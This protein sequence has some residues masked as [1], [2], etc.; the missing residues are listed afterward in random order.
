MTE[1][2][3]AWKTSKKRSNGYKLKED[4]FWFSKYCLEPIGVTI[5]EHITTSFR[6]N[7]CKAL[8]QVRKGKDYS[9]LRISVHN[10]Q[11]LE[12]FAY[13]LAWRFRNSGQMHGVGLQNTIEHL[14]N[15]EKFIGFVNYI[16]VKK[17][18]KISDQKIKRYTF[19]FPFLVFPRSKEGPSEN[20][21]SPRSSRC[22]LRS[23]GG[24]SEEDFCLTQTKSWPPTAIPT[25][26]CVPYERM[27]LHYKADQTK[28]TLG[29][30]HGWNT[31]L[32]RSIISGHLTTIPS[33]N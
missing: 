5:H 20:K 8:F 28:T 3:T 32:P 30:Y 9:Q 31:L 29:H 6:A 18:I 7:D 11:V 2:A 21:K 19:C 17:N 10:T 14:R 15:L 16:N 4:S 23:A 33:W 24:T 12:F 26:M 1:I 25:I 27:N 22:L 13:I